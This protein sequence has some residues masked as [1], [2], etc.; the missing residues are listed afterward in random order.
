VFFVA[1]LPQRLE[2]MNF[3]EAKKQAA[4]EER[5]Q[6]QAEVRHAPPA[7]PDSLVGIPW[8]NTFPPVLPL[9]PTERTRATGTPRAA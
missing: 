9:A 8:L 3:H 6:Q 5:Q 7:L 4:L 2:S 1:L